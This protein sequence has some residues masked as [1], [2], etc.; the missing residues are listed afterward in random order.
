M[1]KEK[2]NYYITLAIFIV[3]I[4]FTI[5]VMNIDVMA[6]GPKDGKV[7]FSTINKKVFEIFGQNDKWDQVS[8]KLLS[9]SVFVELGFI[10]ITIFQIIKRKSLFKIDYD[11]SIF[12]ILYIIFALINV[13]FDYIAIN[14]RPIIEDGKVEASYPSTHTFMT[15]FMLGFLMIEIWCRIKNKAIKNIIYT[16]CVI[17]MIAMPIL[18]VIAGRHWLTDVIGGVILGLFAVM[19]AYSLIYSN[20]LKNNNTCKHNKT[21]NYIQ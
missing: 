17:I 8:D 5:G 21:S 11:I 18:R 20:M 14:N 10:L 7:G 2:R 13:F 6:I 4:I 12:F 3:F 19:L 1:N 9:I 15:V 16:I